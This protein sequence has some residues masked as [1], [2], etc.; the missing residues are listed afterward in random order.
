MG[1]I[2]VVKEKIFNKKICLYPMGIAAKATMDK[3]K[4]YG[5]EIDF[6]SDSNPALWGTEYKGKECVPKEQLV[7]MDQDQLIVIVESLY[8]KEIKRNLYEHGVKNILRIFPEKFLTDKFLEKN[9]ENLDNYVNEI[10]GIFEDERS[11]KVFRHLINAWKMQDIP[12]D[13]FELIYDKEQYF[14]SQIIIRDIDEVFVDVGAYVG[15]TAEKYLKFCDN[16]YEKMHLFELDAEIYQKL[17]KNISNFREGKVEKEKIICYPY[18]LADENK[19]VSF[20]NGDSYSSIMES[21]DTCGNV[22]KMDDSLRNEKV[23]FIKM[24]IEGAEMSSLIGASDIIRK[25][26]PKLAICIYHRPEDMFEIPRYI[27]KLVPE[28]KIY[29]RHYTDM[30]LETVC[31]ATI[32]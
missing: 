27:K 19:E 28:Y 25:Q 29:S 21:F 7:K 26:K 31:Y 16:K 17:E 6:F 18:G 8:Y 20:L 23:T 2:D 9:G 15:D 32:S 24:D 30:V 1:Y 22:R 5:I 14:D 13:Y 11:K 3:I 10:M 12:D 4:A